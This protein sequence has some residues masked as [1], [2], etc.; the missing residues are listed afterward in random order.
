MHKDLKS[1]GQFHE[2]LLDIVKKIAMVLIQR[3]ASIMVAESATGG[4]VQYF[5]TEI[6][7]SSKF[8]LGGIV[9]YSNEL[10]K[11]ALKVPKSVINRYGAVSEETVVAM[12]NG[13]RLCLNADYGL[14][15]SGIAGPS[16]ASP[17]KPVGLVHTA[18]SHREFETITA[19][20]VFTGTRLE[21]K[22]YFTE[23]ALKLFLQALNH[24]G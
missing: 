15:T 20:H 18:V 23:T 4:L 22:L 5:L 9:A 2:S 10:K 7:G 13:I 14:A 3:K 12:A 16:G 19:R 11:T 8:F 24:Q 21:N 6:P 1:F 17:N